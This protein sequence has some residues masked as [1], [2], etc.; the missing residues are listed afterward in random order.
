ME[1]SMTNDEKSNCSNSPY[2]GPFIFMRN[3]RKT[4]ILILQITIVSFINEGNEKYKSIIVVKSD[5]SGFIKVD[6]TKSQYIYIYSKE[7]KVVDYS[8]PIM[9]I[10]N[11]QYL[12]SGT[13]ID[14]Y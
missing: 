13:N 1:Y 5:E 14:V 8:R 7:N 10:K 12:I 2:H 3:K 9:K 6:K 11:C 4:P